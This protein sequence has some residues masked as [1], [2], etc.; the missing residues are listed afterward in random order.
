M[1]ISGY[2]VPHR[3]N[4]P[5]AGMLRVPACWGWA[6]WRRAW[7]HYSDDAA[8]LL[9]AIRARDVQAFDLNGSY[10]NV[11]AL[12][13][14]AQGTLNTWFVRWYAS[15][16]LRGGMTVYPGLSLVRN[17]GFGEDATNCG[18]GGISR[19]F[20]RQKVNSCVPHVDWKALPLEEDPNFFRALEAFYHWQNRQWG[21][22][23]WRQVWRARWRRLTGRNWRESVHAE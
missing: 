7:Q 13:K 19:V 5:A 21:R 11:E 12:E 15:V 9:S 3:Q 20:R 18:K 4:L 10:A 22:P 17:T 14:N 2:F 6:T 1:Q 8:A 23:T 16:F